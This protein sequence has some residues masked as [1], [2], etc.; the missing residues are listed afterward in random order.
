MSSDVKDRAAE[1]RRLTP[2][3]TTGEGA[4]AASKHAAI[5]FSLSLLSELRQEGE[6]EVDIS[7]LCP[8]GIWTPMLQ[9]RLDD[10][11][12]ALSFSG[13]LFQ[14]EEVVAAVGRLLDSP[15]PVTTLPKWR[16]AQVRLLDA[17]PRVMLLAAPVAIA[18]GRRAQRRLRRTLPEAVDRS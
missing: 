4:Y 7:C 14:P 8:D 18:Q 5:G 10:P 6:P 15:R 17:L 12:A 11:G 3:S 1:D 9:E 16:G 2:E 13:K